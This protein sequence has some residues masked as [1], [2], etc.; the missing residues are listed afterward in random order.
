MYQ[1]RNAWINWPVVCAV[2]G[3]LMLRSSF[4]NISTAFW[5]FHQI[6][7]VLSRIQSKSLIF[8]LTWRSGP[9]RPGKFA[10]QNAVSLL[11][12]PRGFLSVLSGRFL[13]SMLRRSTAFWC[14]SESGL[15]SA[16]GRP[17]LGQL[18]RNLNAGLARCNVP[19]HALNEYIHH[20]VTGIRNMLQA[21][22]M[23]AGLGLQWFK[24]SQAG[25]PIF[26]ICLVY[27]WYI[28]STG[29][30]L[31]PTTPLVEKLEAGSGKNNV[32]NTRHCRR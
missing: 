6:S 26:G 5:A 14:S 22:Q 7:Q 16:P 28:P 19:V 18:T 31:N 9:G 10:R 32:G 25:S 27:T 8:S 15:S 21:V 20:L 3:K 2:W 30:L 29:S 12:I 17:G 13:L 4:D 1:S 11:E 24:A 23:E